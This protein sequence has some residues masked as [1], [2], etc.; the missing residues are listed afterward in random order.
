MN[1]RER[2]LNSLSGRPIDRFFR[3]EHG[4]WPTTRERWIREGY[5]AEAGCYHDD[6]G[7]RQF[8]QMDP[9]A[10][11]KINSGY[12]DSP[13]QPKFE[14][15]IVEEDQQHVLYVDEDGITKRVLRQNQDTSMPQFIR[16]P[17]A[18]REDW[19][20]VRAR[21]N[22]DD[23]LARIG[24]PATVVQQCSDPQVATLL[25]ICGAFGHP[26]N[27]LG[28]EG[29]SFILYDDPVLLQEILDNWCELYV[30]LIRALSAL[31]R[32]DSV[33]IWEDMCYKGGPLISPAHFRAFM[34]PYYKRLIEAARDCGV[35]G[36]IVDTDGDALSLIPLF[37]EAGV[38]ALMPF[39]V[40]AGMDVVK[41]RQE[42]GPSFCIIGGIDKRALAQ[43]QA[44]IEA[45][46]ERVLPYFLKSGRYIPTLDHTAPTDVSLESFQYYLQFLRWYEESGP[47]TPPNRT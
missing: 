37:L 39:E 10:R 22:P 6:A 33:L 15:R 28:E 5:P 17:V 32:V 46:V 43:G 40:Q 9:L 31:V 11:I 4:C 3:Y 29:L 36:I 2:F 26:R 25:P 23:A 44:A 19:R 21:L 20:R 34:L 12:T 14:R 18:G 35:E 42:F 7:F 30:E 13:Y 38:N 27:L 1:G 24:D 41:I 45:E 8:F 47:R 16:F